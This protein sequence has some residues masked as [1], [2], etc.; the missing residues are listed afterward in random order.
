MAT[1]VNP[2]SARHRWWLR[3]TAHQQPPCKAR[4]HS[5]AYTGHSCGTGLT[6]GTILHP[7]TTA[8]WAHQ[9]PVQA[10][11]L[12]CHR[13]ARRLLN[14]ATRGRL[15]VSVRMPHAAIFSPGAFLPG[16]AFLMRFSV[17]QA[18]EAVANLPLRLAVRAHC[19]HTVLR[20]TLEALI[21]SRGI[22]EYSHRTPGVLTHSTGTPPRDNTQRGM[23]CFRQSAPSLVLL[24]R[25]LEGVRMT[26]GVVAGAGAARG[27]A[28]CA[29][30]AAAVDV[31]RRRAALGARGGADL[32]AVGAARDGLRGDP[33]AQGASRGRAHGYAAWAMGEGRQ[34]SAY[35][36]RVP[37]YRGQDSPL[38][39]VGMYA[40]CWKY[41][42]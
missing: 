17:W 6:G 42:E 36:R 31:R 11:S 39:V 4:P 14:A 28:A 19:G 38:G 1:E 3:V 32:A 37:E 7:L 15:Y 12:P 21:H 23:R 22:P 40:E 34:V 29:E 41:S 18:E 16:F 10:A 2:Y 33:E 24:E 5:D 25:M 26:Q 9:G 8:A 30:P 35:A 13:P 27:G 20:G